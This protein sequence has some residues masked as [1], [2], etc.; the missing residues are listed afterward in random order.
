MAKNEFDS[1]AKAVPHCTMCGWS[2]VINMSN[3]TTPK[4]VTE[5]ANKVMSE[6]L[7]NQHGVTK[8]GVAKGKR[9]I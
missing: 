7:R 9:W 1:G 8:K 2:V 3:K 4:Q 5:R 6:H